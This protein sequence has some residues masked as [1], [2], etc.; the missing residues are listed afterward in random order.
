MPKIAILNSTKA[1]DYESNRIIEEFDKLQIPVVPLNVAKTIV[2][3]NAPQITV[4]MP[5][6]QQNLHNLKEFDGFIVRQ[7]FS[8]MKLTINV[9]RWVKHSLK[10]PIFDNNLVQSQYLVNKVTEGFE[11]LQYNLPYPKTLYF[12]D[13][14]MLFAN[15]EFIEQYLNAYPMVVKHLS[16]GKGYGVFK[17]DSRQELIEF[18]QELAQTHHKKEKAV[19]LYLLQEFLHIDKE[20]RV[21]VLNNKVIGAMQRIPQAGDFRANY[22]RG[23]TV[24]PATVTPAMQK[25][26]LKAVQASN[27]VFSGV[28]YAITKDGKHILLEVNRTPGFEGFEQAT[29]INV[30]KIFVDYLRESWGWA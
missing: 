20:F 6:Y 28:D 11:A 25:L 13:L 21:L 17:M 30:A 29:G 5:D 10:R 1:L 12:T 23:G 14:D 15:T 4:Q 18:F 7:V 9:V 8:V 2:K 19:R 22:S 24:K 16:K 27:V 26:A 3:F